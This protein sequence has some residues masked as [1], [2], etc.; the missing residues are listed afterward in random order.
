MKVWTLKAIVQKT[1]SY[2]PWPHQVNF[3]FQKYITRGVHLTDALFED[4]L[5]HCSNHV[6][7]FRKY[8]PNKKTPTSL[9]IGTGWYPIVPVGLYLSGGA[10]I[11]TI[12]ISSLLS[13]E[14][15][16][17]TLDKYDEW[18]KA[19]RLA[20]YLPDIDMERFAK[21]L[22]LRAT[23]LQRSVAE[24][25]KELNITSIVGDARKIDLP[26]HSIDLLNSNNTFEH[27]YPVIL[28]PILVEFRR[29]LAV[30]G[31]MSHQID[32]SDHF[33][34]LDKSITI[35]NF[36]RFTDEQWSRIDNDIQPQNRTRFPEFIK[37]LD[38]TGFEV[39]ETMNREGSL[40]ELDTVPVA[41][42]YKVYTPAELAISHSLIIARGKV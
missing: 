22:S 6:R 12:D 39:L 35:Y 37:M 31:I 32:M 4:K 15:L 41:D 28:R 11:Y 30:D 5:I 25:L 2:L 34:H 42:K 10:A 20:Q 38:E 18:Q 13:P 1:I 26:S 33:A 8:A 36:L 19:G 3:L 7:Y 16:S 14:R 27:I 9:E 29:L 40:A 21:L 23:V 24:T 17:N